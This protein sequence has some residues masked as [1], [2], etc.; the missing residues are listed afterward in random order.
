MDGDGCKRGFRGDLRRKTGEDLDSAQ[1]R[2]YHDPDALPET[3]HVLYTK[4]NQSS[5]GTDGV[6]PQQQGAVGGFVDGECVHPRSQRNACGEVVGSGHRSP[7]CVGNVLP[8]MQP[9]NS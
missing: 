4:Q 1:T 8:N 2:T 7:A 6:R 9:S 5:S 3:K